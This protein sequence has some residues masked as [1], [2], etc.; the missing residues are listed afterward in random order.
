M[1]SC[2]RMSPFPL[3]QLLVILNQTRNIDKLSVSHQ[4]GLPSGLEKLVPCRL[5][6]VRG[7]TSDDGFMGARRSTG[8]DSAWWFLVSHAYLGATASDLGGVGECAN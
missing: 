8:R 5:I 1:T 4:S 2:W 7:R 6:G 3:R